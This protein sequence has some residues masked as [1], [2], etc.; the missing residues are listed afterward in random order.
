MSSIL[1]RF[2]V[3]HIPT[4]RVNY[5]GNVYT[6][7]VMGGTG[8]VLYNCYDVATHYIMSYKEKTNRVIMQ[9]IKGIGVSLGIGIVSPV[10][11]PIIYLSCP[12]IVAYSFIDY[13]INDD[14]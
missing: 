13:V 9:S 1:A 14:H 5:L 6:Y 7:T 4:S 12:I 10:L 8:A 3:R 11:I 2:L